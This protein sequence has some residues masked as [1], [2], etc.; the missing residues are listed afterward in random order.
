MYYMY[1]YNLCMTFD[2]NVIIMWFEVTLMQDESMR[3]SQRALSFYY[4]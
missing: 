4:S 3:N 2:A 1:M